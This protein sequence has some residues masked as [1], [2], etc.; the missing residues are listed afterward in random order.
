MPYTPTD[1]KNTPSTDTPISA[2]NLN[3]LEQGVVNATAL[4]E[5]QVSY[6]D[7]TNKPTLLT[8]GTTAT[9]AKAG[10]Y[11]P[12]WSEVTGKPATFAPT[13]GTT[14]TTA[15]AG[16]YAPPNATATTYGMVKIATAT[17][18]TVAP[19]AA[20]AT[21]SRTYMVQNLESGQ[22]VVNVPWV[23]TTYTLPVATTSVVGGVKKAFGVE[24]T[25]GEDLVAI[26][27]TINEL[28]ASLRDAGIMD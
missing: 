14:A 8:I 26:K 15:K 18:Q 10:N 16:D 25:T 28:L 5:A 24:D 3:K 22:L 1:W 17:I 19:S 21:A 20:T 7:L 2:E 9:T 13:I 23:N 11:A 4:A 12:A 27:N 6:N